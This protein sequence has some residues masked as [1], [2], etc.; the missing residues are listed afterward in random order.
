MAR[1]RAEV[2]AAAGSRYT[3]SANTLA[4]PQAIEAGPSASPWW[5]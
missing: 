2:L 5:G 3:Y 4:Y 1:N